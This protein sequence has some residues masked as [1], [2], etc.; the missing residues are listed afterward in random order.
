MPNK[1]I[2]VVTSLTELRALSRVSDKDLARVLDGTDGDDEFLYV[3]ASEEVDDD[4]SVI[5]PDFKLTT[6]PGR[7]IKVG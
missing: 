7:W 1:Q 5:K 2:K 6:Q 3:A 4:D